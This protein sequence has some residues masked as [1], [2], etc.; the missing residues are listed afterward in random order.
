ME[1]QRGIRPNLLMASNWWNWGKKGQ[2]YL[3][4]G[5]KELRH[6]PEGHT[7]IGETCWK[8]ES[9]GWF[10]KE[11]TRSGSAEQH[12]GNINTAAARNSNYLLNVG[13]DKDGRIIESSLQTL[14]KIGELRKK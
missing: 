8:L 2:R 11:G 12:L 10:W 5:V 13:P 14:K 9:K 6:F 1:F 7:E 3:D 4:I